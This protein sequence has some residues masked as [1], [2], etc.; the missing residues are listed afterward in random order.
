MGWGSSATDNFNKLAKQK[1]EM[2]KKMKRGPYDHHAKEP[3]KDLPK[4]DPWI[5]AHLSAWDR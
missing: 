5:K 4:D 2:A 1:K 3:V